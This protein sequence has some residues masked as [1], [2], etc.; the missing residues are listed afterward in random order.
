MRATVFDFP[1]YLRPEVPGCL[2]SRH[3]VPVPLTAPDA[4]LTTKDLASDDRRRLLDC[5]AHIV[6]LPLLASFVSQVARM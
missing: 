3:G 1:F 6:V 2:A 5:P 4:A